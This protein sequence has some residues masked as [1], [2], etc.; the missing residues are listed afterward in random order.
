M[1]QYK[2]MPGQGDRSGWVG[3]HPQKSTIGGTP[4]KN[5]GIGDGI[6]YFS[7]AETRERDNIGSVN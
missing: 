6:G 3:E 5:W 1:P 7:E 2:G 4:S